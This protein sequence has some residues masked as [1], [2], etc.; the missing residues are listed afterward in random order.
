[1]SHIENQIII[2]DNNKYTDDPIVGRIREKFGDDIIQQEIFIES[3]NIFT[4][5]KNDDGFVIDLDEVYQWMGFT[6]KDHAK[7]KL[8]TSLDEN[9]DYISL[10]RSGERLDGGQNKETIMIKLKS[11]KDFCMVAQTQKAKQI[12]SYFITIEEVVLEHLQETQAIQLKEKDKLIEQK[13]QE[14]QDEQARLLKEN[15]EKDKLIEQKKQEL[16]KFFQ[17]Y[18][19]VEKIEYLYIFS[20]DKRGYYKVGRTRITPKKRKDGLQTACVDDIEIL[21]E[22][23]THNSIILEDVVHYILD[24]YR[25]N[26]NREHFQCDVNFIKMI[27][28]LAGGMLNTLKSAYPDIIREEL[29]E[30]VNENVN[31]SSKVVLEKVIAPKGYRLQHYVEFLER[32][33]EI[34]QDKYSM[35]YSSDLIA[36]FKSKFDVSE[37]VIRNYMFQ[38]AKQLNYVCNNHCGRVSGVTH[39]KRGYN[40][41]KRIDIN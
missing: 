33:Y 28:E 16:L 8:E 25:S 37:H 32:N 39:G 34:V 40:F 26:S 29:I 17:T 19:E 24:R 30:R 9:V 14:F 3:F 36:H 38:A 31:I 11:F 13:E 2:S 18:E 10:L 41:L 5:Y 4:K 23:R 27:I 7:R 20:T 35:V 15:E 12:R 6:R 1:M 22:Y 21:F